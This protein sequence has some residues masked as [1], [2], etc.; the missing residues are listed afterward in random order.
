MKEWPPTPITE[1]LK[2]CS[3]RIEFNNKLVCEIISDEVGHPVAVN[4]VM[5]AQCVVFG[6]KPN[7][8]LLKM[9]VIRN[10]KELLSYVPFGFYNAVRAEEIIRKAYTLMEDDNRSLSHLSRVI[11]SCVETGVLSLDTTEAMARD[12]P[13][14]EKINE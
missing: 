3:K 2:P 1:Y 12:M 14:L 4:P 5:C 10:Y 11:I 6:G 7:E 9:H 8:Q 13:K